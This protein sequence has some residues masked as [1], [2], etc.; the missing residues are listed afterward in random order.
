ML[1]FS[2][3]R[4]F[5]EWLPTPLGRYKLRA[6]YSKGRGSK[7]ITEDDFLRCYSQVLNF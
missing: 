2:L 3:K 5:Y 1:R 4:D 6:E 7:H